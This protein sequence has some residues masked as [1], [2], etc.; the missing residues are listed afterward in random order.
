MLPLGA[1]G[2]GWRG[3]DDVGCC[4][5]LAVPVVL[6]PLTLVRLLEPLPSVGS[7]AL[8]HL[9]PLI[10]RSCPSLPPYPPIMPNRT[11]FGWA[12][13]RACLPE[14]P[15]PPAIP[16]PPLAAL[17]ARGQWRGPLP[18]SVWTRPRAVKQGQ[19]G[20]SVRTTSHRKG[21]MKSSGA[22]PEWLWEC[23]MEACEACERL[24][25]F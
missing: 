15:L 18:S 25:G 20:G 2:G 3:N 11:T 23:G 22:F 16:G 10:Y 12:P 24:L 6:S 13:K 8:S 7:G 9:M 17:D 4:R 19:S 14:F 5:K 21:N 1:L